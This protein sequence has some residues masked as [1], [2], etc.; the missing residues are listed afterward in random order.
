MDLPRSPNLH[1]DKLAAVFNNTTNTYKYYW[2]LALLDHLPYH[3]SEIFINDLAV[4]M[5]SKVWY[6][7]NYFRLSFGKQDKIVRAVEKERRG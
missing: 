4:T 2:F 3:S 1:I 5:I 7:V 6:P